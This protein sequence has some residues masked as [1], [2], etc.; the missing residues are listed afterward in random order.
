[1]QSYAQKAGTSTDN[2]ETEIISLSFFGETLQLP[3][4]IDSTHIMIQ[5]NNPTEQDH[6]ELEPLKVDMSSSQAHYS[7]T[8]TDKRPRGDIASRNILS[9]NVPGIWR[10][11]E[12]VFVPPPGTSR[13]LVDTTTNRNDHR[14]MSS[15]S[16]DILI[17]FVMSGGMQSLIIRNELAAELSRDDRRGEFDFQTVLSLVNA[18]N[19]PESVG[20]TW[21]LNDLRDH[22]NDVNVVDLEDT[23]L[24]IAKTDEVEGKSAVFRFV[25]FDDAGNYRFDAK[26]TIVGQQASATAD[27][28]IESFLR[29][30]ANEEPP[31]D[32]EDE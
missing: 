22:R 29:P 31:N 10:V 4:D 1:M 21:V 27:S 8:L 7:L 19:L 24:L 25:A 32:P 15:S 17:R 23:R 3:A 13:I 16:L 11:N 9:S 30:P 18:E 28:L 2:S 12:F 6:A 5:R 26:M 14:S 20:R